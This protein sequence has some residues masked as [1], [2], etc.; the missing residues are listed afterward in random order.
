LA[1]VKIYER[2]KKTMKKPTKI[3]KK[4]NYFPY[5]C[6]VKRNYNKTGEVKREAQREVAKWC[7]DVAKY[8]TTVILVTS[9]LGEFRQKWLVYIIGL[10]LVTILFYYGI[11]TLN[12]KQ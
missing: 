10:V 1:I 12:K 9:F 7:M 3:I 5:L 11:Q 8:I 4:S 2:Y 6:R